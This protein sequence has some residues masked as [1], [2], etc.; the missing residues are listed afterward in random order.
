MH[1][2]D[3][4]S[5]E[6]LRA[7]LSDAAY[8]AFRTRLQAIVM[9]KQGHTAVA[10]AGSLGVGRR[11][12]QDWVYWYNTRGLARLAGRVPP[13]KAPPLSP[14]NLEQFLA[15]MEAGPRAE[16]QVCAL[17]GIEGR[18]ILLEEFGVARGLSTV[19]R[20]LE[21]ARFAKLMPRP[22]HP[23]SDPAAQ[24]AFLKRSCPANSR[25]SGRPTRAR[26]S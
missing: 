17:R 2:V 1:I 18:R 23:Q 22:R 20:L 16:D 9:A 4:L 3:G 12:V 7:R 8:G 11:T 14:E 25:R 5:L 13:G 19:Y 24:E 6:E 21:A 10:I 15:R 26:P